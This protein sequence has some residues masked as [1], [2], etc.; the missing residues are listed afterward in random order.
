MHPNGSVDRRISI[1]QGKRL[2]AGVQIYAR[3][4]DTLQTR[5]ER[6]FDHLSPV[7]F[8]AFKVKVRMGINQ[9]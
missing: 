9:Q 2:S 4:K 3:I 8:E 6:P 7:G 5:L 1:R